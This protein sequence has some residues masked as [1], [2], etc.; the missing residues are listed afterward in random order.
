[1]H[2]ALQTL[3]ICCFRSVSQCSEFLNIKISVVVLQR[4]VSDDLYRIKLNTFFR[5]SGH[6]PKDYWSVLWVAREPQPDRR[7]EHI[8][9]GA[10]PRRHT[11][12]PHAHH[13][14]AGR[15]RRQAAGKWHSGMVRLPTVIHWRDNRPLD[16]IDD[17]KKKTKLPQK[18][19][20]LLR[21]A[22]FSASKKAFLRNTNSLLLLFLQ[23]SKFV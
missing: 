22:C 18:P 21:Q 15:G 2:K 10:V 1:M 20:L 14:P 13:Q 7:R 17:A 12:L 19:R 16:I 9:G 11:R 4:I 5:F 8:P 6:E 23:C 3:N